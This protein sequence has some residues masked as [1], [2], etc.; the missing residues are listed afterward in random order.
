[1]SVK[2]ILASAVLGAGVIMTSAIPAVAANAA[3][4]PGQSASAP[5]A[6]TGYDRCPANHLCIFNGENG[7]GDYCTYSEAS[8]AD[9]VTG[10][11]F[12]QLG[13]EVRSVWN[14]HSYI[15]QF[16]MWKNYSHPINYANPNDRGN[17]PG[18]Y[19]IRSFAQA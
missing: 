19:Q 1:M 8:T 3:T 11:N 14:R 5:A 16:Y 6:A 18:T 2:R 10:C 9:S 12:L 7:T 4:V 17:A 15:E 13:W